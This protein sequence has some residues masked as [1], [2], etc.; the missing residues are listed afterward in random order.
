MN[1]Q[2]LW[3]AGL[4]LASALPLA[5]QEHRAEAKF[6]GTGTGQRSVRMDL[7]VGDYKIVPGGSD[8]VVVTWTGRT[9]AR[10]HA[11]VT[12]SGNEARVTTSGPHTGNND[13]HF[14]IEL[15]QKSDIAAHISV[16]DASFGAFQGDEDIS[17]T[18][19]DLRIE[20]ADP[21]AFAEVTASTNIGDV[22]GG[23]FEATQK[24]F[25][26]KTMH[27]TGPGHRRLKLHVGTGDVS[28]SKASQ[29]TM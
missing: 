22:S 16:G 25:L 18:I 5:A 6:S 8:E 23:P 4:L 2:V 28:I 3:A 19:G 15:P 13:V 1:K 26:G 9:A 7:G 27:W 14:T 24:G 12:V 17:L 21:D 11:E 20:V 29:A 10:S